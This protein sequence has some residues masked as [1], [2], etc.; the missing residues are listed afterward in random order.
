MPEAE[1]VEPNPW[2]RRWYALLGLGHHLRRLF[3]GALAPVDQLYLN[4]WCDEPGG[5]DVVHYHLDDA[6]LER[7]GE[8][9]RRTGFS[10]NDI[11]TTALGLALARWSGDR[12]TEVRRFNILIPADMRPRHSSV[13]SFANHLSSYLVDFDRARMPDAR[14]MLEATYSQVRRQAAV[15]EPQK[16]LLA[17]NAV[18]GFTPISWIQG[19]MYSAK[20]TPLNYSFSNLIPISPRDNGGM[21]GTRTWTACHLRILTPNAYLNGVNTTVIRYAGKLCFNFNHKTGVVPR[22]EVEDLV[23]R[24]EEALAEVVFAARQQERRPVAIPVPTEVPA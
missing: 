22:Q 10:T 23:E 6:V 19:A 17:E 1:V 16:K 5:N 13:R 21:F 12:G 4:R 11:L 20:R 15:Q 18:A 14:A 9:K 7:L 8:I 2:R 24:F 3:L